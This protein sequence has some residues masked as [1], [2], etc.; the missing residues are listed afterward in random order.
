[1]MWA[2]SRWRVAPARTAASAPGPACSVRTTELTDPDTTKP[3]G[4]AAPARRPGT[5]DGPSPPRR[6]A[7]LRG[8]RRA[9]RCA[10]CAAR[11]GHQP[12]DSAA[13]RLASGPDEEI[14]ALRGRSGS[15]RKQHLPEPG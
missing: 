13:T 11:A 6:E 14:R 2:P 8:R 3:A 10:T 5:L 4:A 15:Q 7:H 9:V 12:K 1:T